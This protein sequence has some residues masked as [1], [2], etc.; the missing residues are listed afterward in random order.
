MRGKVHWSRDSDGE[1]T[2]GWVVPLQ[3]LLGSDCLATSNSMLWSWVKCLEVSCLSHA[4]C[5][6]EKCLPKAAPRD[7]I[8]GVEQLLGAQ[9]RSTTGSLLLEG[10]N[11]AKINQLEETRAVG[12]DTPDEWGKCPGLFQAPTAKGGKTGA[13]PVSGMA[14]GNK[15]SVGDKEVLV[16]RVAL[17]TIWGD[18]TGAELGVALPRQAAAAA[19]SLMLNN[20]EKFTGFIIKNT[21][22]VPTQTGAQR[23]GVRQVRDMEKVQWP[24]YLTVSVMTT[25]LIFPQHASSFTRLWLSQ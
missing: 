20:T 3:K 19:H 25:S 4:A 6:P 13:R 17:P 11:K 8:P 18:A 9:L 14:V 23:E 15:V 5:T 2:Q 1:G 21:C 7:Q 12:R 24:C 10:I 16:L 22:L